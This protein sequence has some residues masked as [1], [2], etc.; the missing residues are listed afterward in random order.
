MSK[1]SGLVLAF[2]KARGR[3][4]MAIQPNVSTRKIPKQ[5]RA[6]GTSNFLIE[7]T[8]QFLRKH[9]YSKLSTNKIA[10]LAGVSIGTLYQYFSSKEALLVALIEKQFESDFQMVQRLIEVDDDDSFEG[11]V[12]RIIGAVL[13]MFSEQTQLRL[14]I[15][16]QARKLSLL[17][18]RESFQQKIRN[19]LLDNFDRFSRGVYKKPGELSMYVVTSAVIGTLFAAAQERPEYLTDPDFK[20]QLTRLI[21]GYYIKVEH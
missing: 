11:G 14:V 10:E 8:A 1:C 15:Y 21:L 17:K 13:K 7:A 6:I 5:D 2:E 18:T 16:E 4:V 3:R 20:A 12:D 19:L 9:H